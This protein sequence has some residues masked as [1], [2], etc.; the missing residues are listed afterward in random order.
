MMIVPLAELASMSVRLKQYQKATFIKSIR[1]FALTVEHAQTFV[2]L[3]L[4]I[5][6][7]IN[8]KKLRAVS[9]DTA[10][11][12]KD[13]TLLSPKLTEYQHFSLNH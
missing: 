12:I 13:C 9:N 11:F 4:F 6:N 10:F 2:L 1:M 5:R 7:S 8:L 3:K